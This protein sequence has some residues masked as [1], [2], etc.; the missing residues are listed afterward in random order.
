MRRS[1]VTFAA[2]TTITCAAGLA[3]CTS[4]HA[5]A[6]TTT[7][8]IPA[9]AAV[10]RIGST[11]VSIAFPGS[12]G[13]ERDPPALAAIL[14]AHTSVTTW[15]IGDVGALRDHSYELVMATFPPGSATTSID[16]FLA[17]YASAPNTTMF[18]SPALHEVSTIPFSTGTRYSGITAF[19]IGRV[20]VMAVDF[21]SVKA[22]VVRFLSSLQLV[23]PRR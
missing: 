5:S 15:D 23:S 3:G 17:G 16:R 9:R 22:D 1:G 14:P 11:A 7:T 18:G 19:N 13:I 10:Y 21:D 12:P 2:L 20:L 8:T 4:H 6:T